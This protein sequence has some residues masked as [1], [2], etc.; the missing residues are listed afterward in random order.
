MSLWSLV[1]RVYAEF[2]ED[3]IPTVAGGIAFFVLL[4]LFPA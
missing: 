4:A 3:R 1:K 2:F